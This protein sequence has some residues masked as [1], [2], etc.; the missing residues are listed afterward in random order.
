MRL[1]PT[2]AYE[3]MWIYYII[4]AVNLLHASITLCGHLHGSVSQKIYY[5]DNQ[6]NAYIVMTMTF[7]KNS[8]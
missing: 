4:T 6:I 3:N 8:I 7:L 2:N 5:T 1:K